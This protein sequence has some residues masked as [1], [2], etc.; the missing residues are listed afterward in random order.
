MS[1][2]VSTHP[3]AIATVY[4]DCSGVLDSDAPEWAW[5]EFIEDLRCVLDGSAGVESGLFINNKSFTGFDGY[6]DANRWSGRENRVILEGEQTEISISEHFGIA[7]VCLAPLDPDE[8]SH[9][10]ACEYAAPY[11]NELLKVA[12][13]K[14]FL[15]KVGTFSN[16]ESIYERL[17]AA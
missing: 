1:R 16:G 14:S 11:F 17:Q 6:S 12:Y 9:R 4:L 13:P 2:S 5:Q 15:T 8:P 7:A 10:H 3:N